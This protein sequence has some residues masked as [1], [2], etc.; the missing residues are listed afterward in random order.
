M[1]DMIAAAWR[2]VHASVNCRP[3]GSEHLSREGACRQSRS[4]KSI[5]FDSGKDQPWSAFSSDRASLLPKIPWDRIEPAPH[6][7]KGNQQ[8]IFPAFRKAT[9]HPIWLCQAAKVRHS[10]GRQHSLSL[11]AQRSSR[12]TVQAQTSRVAPAKQIPEGIQ[13]WLSG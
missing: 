10:L 12:R 4:R 13:S 7:D 11:A 1:L 9:T 3:K 5:T 6:C 8:Q 2:R